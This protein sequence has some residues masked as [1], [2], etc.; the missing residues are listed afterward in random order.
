MPIA[1][2]SKIKLL[3]GRFYIVV[4]DPGTED[5]AVED[6]YYIIGEFEVEQ[7]GQFEE[8]LLDALEEYQ[9]EIFTHLENEG[10]FNPSHHIYVVPQAYWVSLEDLKFDP[11]QRYLLKMA[12]LKR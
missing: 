2:P 12:N 9:D 1:A 6:K 8:K 5:G 4:C 10:E 3:T 11:V 7:Q